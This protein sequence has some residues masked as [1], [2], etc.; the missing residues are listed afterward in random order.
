[1]CSIVV[2]YSFPVTGGGLLECVV[3]EYFFYPALLWT[4]SNTEKIGRGHNAKHKTLHDS[5]AV[6]E[7]TVNTHE[8][9]PVCNDQGL[10]SLHDSWAVTEST[11]NTHTKES[12]FVTIKVFGR[13]RTNSKLWSLCARVRLEQSNIDTLWKLSLY[14][15]SYF[16]NDISRSYIFFLCHPSPL[17]YIFLTAWTLF[18]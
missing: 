9:K 18:T 11:V 3:L 17:L 2:F 14:N 6:T 13:S 5:W 10:P 4:A 8:R 1:M 16:F 7:S 15:R 12:M